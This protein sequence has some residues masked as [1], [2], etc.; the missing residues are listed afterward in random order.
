M[1]RLFW[2]IVFVLAMAVSLP[3]KEVQVNFSWDCN[4]E[5]NMA[6]YTLYKRLAAQTYDYENPDT[7]IPCVVAEGI[8]EP[9]LGSIIWE[10]PDGVSTVYH[11][12]ARA[13][14]TDDPVKYSDNSNEVSYTVDLR[15]LPMPTDFVGVWNEANET[16][17]L[18]WEQLNPERVKVW[19]VM[20]GE[21]EGGPYTD[22]YAVENTGQTSYTASVPIVAPPGVITTKYFVL[23]AEAEFDLE[24][25][26]TAEVRV[27]I[28]KTE[29]PSAI[30]N[31]I[32]ETVE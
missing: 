18:T 22:E 24:S 13:Y 27:D 5:T 16:V 19:R 11:F 21:T 8:C 23:K 4:T 15:V 2:T 1:K 31:L 29:A 6:G 26:V 14:N 25:S 12:V 9:C 30:I 10:A 3:A 20:Y 32:I 17:D 28:D 7:V